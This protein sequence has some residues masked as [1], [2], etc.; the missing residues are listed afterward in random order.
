MESKLNLVIVG[1]P[2]CGKSH[3]GKL[4]AKTL[5]REFIDLDAVVVKNAGMSIPE[6]FAKFGEPRFRELER[7]A[8]EEVAKRKN[9]VIAT[10]G[11]TI[12]QPGAPELFRAT[13]KI[14]YL[15]RPLEELQTAH[16]RP[17]SSDRKA[18]EKLYAARREKYEAAAD[19]TVENTGVAPEEAARQVAAAFLKYL[20]E[21]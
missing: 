2:G 6:I 10:G 16:G 9:V 19:F 1:M 7:T 18:V 5:D 17:L 3:V 11:G 8:A 20:R 13:G 15:K 12:V 4:V 21:N 14:C